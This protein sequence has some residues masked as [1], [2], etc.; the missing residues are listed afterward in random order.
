MV[1]PAERGR[2]EPDNRTEEQKKEEAAYYKAK[3]MKSAKP[4]KDPNAIPAPLLDPPSFEEIKA[5]DMTDWILN[6]FDPFMLG[7]EENKKLKPPSKKVVKDLWGDEVEVRGQ[8]DKDGKLCG[9]G[10]H[11]NR[12]KHE[13]TAWWYDDR[14]YGKC[15]V[16]GLNM[17]ASVFETFD[18]MAHGKCA[19]RQAS[20]RHV[21]FVYRKDQDISYKP[22]EEDEAYFNLDNGNYKKAKEE[23]WKDYTALKKTY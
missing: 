23:N 11:R 2:D 14:M 19:M 22:V 3:L 13:V 17:M 10:V 15:H 6:K 1:E 5:E 7:L 20:Y 8:K 4:E 18:N 21:N 12:H 9:K 16:N